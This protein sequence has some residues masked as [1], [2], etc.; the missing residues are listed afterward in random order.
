MNA[1]VNRGIHVE[2]LIQEA[3]HMEVVSISSMQTDRIVISPSKAFLVLSYTEHLYYMA[4]DR[5]IS[6]GPEYPVNT[7]YDNVWIDDS[8]PIPVYKIP[9]DRIISKLKLLMLADC[10]MDP[11]QIVFMPKMRELLK[12]A[13]YENNI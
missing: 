10:D 3:E 9:L 7:F 6:P 8:G 1:T 2:I 4:L 11:R 13:G 5:K 12:L